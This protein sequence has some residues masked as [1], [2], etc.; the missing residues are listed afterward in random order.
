ME[1]IVE[2]IIHEDKYYQN[3]GWPIFLAF[4]IAAAILWP[5][6]RYLNRKQEDRVLVD[7]KTGQPVVVE[8]G[9]GHS[10]FFIPV[11]FWAPIMVLIGLVVFIVRL[12]G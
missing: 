5:L 7:Q 3:H 1:L 11:E 8:S 2:A 4:V 10:F 12:A 9:G 6:G